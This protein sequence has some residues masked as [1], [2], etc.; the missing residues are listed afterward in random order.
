MQ[1]LRPTLPDGQL[2][3]G[4][5]LTRGRH[6]RPEAEY[7]I[8]DEDEE[9]GDEEGSRREDA[10]GVSS[11]E[12]V[13][14]AIEEWDP[15]AV[16]LALAM[17]S[18]DGK[19]EP[20]AVLKSLDRPRL[21]EVGGWSL[22]DG[23]PIDDWWTAADAEGASHSASATARADHRWARAEARAVRRPCR[24]GDRR[25]VCVTVSLHGCWLLRP[26]AAVVLGVAGRWIRRSV[27]RPLD[28]AAHTWNAGVPGLTGDGQGRLESRADSPPV[29]WMICGWT[30]LNPVPADVRRSCSAATPTAGAGGGA[31]FGGVGVSG[32]RYIAWTS[33]SSCTVGPTTAMPVPASSAS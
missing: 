21:V 26:L 13:V 24:D 11:V 6:L 16:R 7:L 19:V 30:A 15:R 1:G 8:S 28:D 5:R 10:R 32:V 9:E 17:A 3:P 18:D 25:E 20:H 23:V 22:F 31:H 27:V 2:I 12:T 29:K 4:I 14:I 33:S